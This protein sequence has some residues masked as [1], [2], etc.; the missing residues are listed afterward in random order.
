[1][2]VCIC[3]K[4]ALKYHPALFPGT[5]KKLRTQGNELFRNFAPT[6]TQHAPRYRIKKYFN[7]KQKHTQLTKTFAFSNPFLKTYDD[8]LYL[9]VI[10]EH[11]A[12]NFPWRCGEDGVLG[13]IWQNINIFAG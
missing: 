11:T 13:N 2:Y 10:I 5:N 3:Q 7:T 1:M 6:F 12:D 9:R 8:T 4:R